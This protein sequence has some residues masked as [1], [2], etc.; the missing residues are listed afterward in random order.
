MT[1]VND[2]VLKIHPLEAEEQAEIGEKLAR[3][4]SHAMAALSFSLSWQSENARHSDCFVDSKLNLWRDI[5]PPQIEPDLMDKPVGHVATRAFVAGELL[6]SYREQDCLPIPSRA[7]TRNL[8]KYHIEPRPGRFYPKGFIGGVRGIFPEDRSPFRMAEVREDG[9]TVDL[10]HPLA[11]R[12]LTL[13]A[14]IQDVWA[15]CEEHGG[16]C[17]DTAELVTKNGPGM[18]ARWRGRETDFWSD[19]PFVRLDPSPDGVFYETPRMVHHL[20][21]TALTQIEDLYRRLIPKG[22]RILDLMSSWT[23]HISSDLEPDQ[24]TGLGMNR[25]ELDAN[26]LLAERLVH[27]LNLDPGLPL[28]DQSFDAV[29][30]TVSVEYLTK[31]QEVFAQVR[32]VLRPGGRFVV[33]FSDRW[34][35]PKVIKVWQDVHEFERVGLVLEYFLRDGGFSNLQTWSLRGLPRPADDKY[36]DRMAQSDPIY[37]VWGENAP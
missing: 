34:F 17:Q 2:P 25:T 19:I 11:G 4:H 26:R 14:R 15:A 23:S 36:A 28:P 9:L 16:A 21:A 30:C 22:A 32:R 33:T 12:T 8:R 24:V 5:L 10:N 18:Q 6:P 29:I 35:P 3:T 37:A 7:F 13:E 1:K 20:D 31:P 27:D